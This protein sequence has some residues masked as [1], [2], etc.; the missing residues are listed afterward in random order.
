MTRR[1]STDRRLREG[2]PPG[3]LLVASL[4]LALCAALLLP[5]AAPAAVA[6]AI[7]GT[8]FSR[9]TESSAALSAAVDPGS[10]K[11]GARFQY[12]TLAAFEAHGFEG[13]QL[14]PAADISLPTKVVGSGDTVAGSN[15]IA[16]V[17]T[18]AGAFGVGQAISGAGIPAATTI[19]AVGADGEG[20]VTQL[21]LSKPLGAT[22]GGVKLEATGPQPI[23]AALGALAPAA[24]YVFRVHAKNL[25][26]EEKDGP[27]L[28]FYTLAPAPSF[29]SCPNDAFRTGGLAPAAR[30]SALLPDCRAYEQASP[31]EKDG[32]DALG[33]KV[34]SRAAATGGAVTFG[35]AFGMPD[36]EGA[37]A[38]PFF[39]ARRDPTGWSST[40]LLPPASLGE[41]GAYLRG[42]TPDFSATY[43]SATRKGAPDTTALFELHPDGTPPTRI[44]PY[45]P[46]S[47]NTDYE[48]AGAA[49]DGSTVLVGAPLALAGEEGGETIPGS[50]PGHP[51]VYAW[52]RATGGL[53]L[54]GR[55]NTLEETEE[56]L[57]KGAYAGP[58]EWAFGNAGLGLSPEVAA[59]LYYLT[60][61]HAVSADGSL[62]FTSL[63]DGR[64]YRRLHPGEPQSA[65]DSEGDCT[66]PDKACTVEISAS[67]RTV[68]DPAG[69]APAIFMA[70]SADGSRAFFASSQM[71]TDD[72]NTGPEQPE[73][74][75]GRAKPNDEAPAGEVEEDFV[76]AHAVGLAVDP[77]GEHLYWAD[78]ARGTIG[79]ARLD[80]AGEATQLEPNFLS[81]P[82]VPEGI[83]E[84]EV[85]VGK[86]LQF[87][88]V[89]VP[90]HPRYV[91]L[92]GEYIYWTNTGRSG[93][94][95][96][97]PLDGGGTIG[98]AK[99]SGEGADEI[100][101]AFICGEDKDEPGERRVSN[102]QG[103]AV[104]E[105]HVYWAN[106]AA[107]PIFNSIWRAASGGGEVEKA[108]QTKANRTPYGVALSGGRVYFT[109][110]SAGG[111]GGFVS[112]APATGGEEESNHIYEEGLR[113]LAIAGD[114][115]YWAAQKE[116]AIGRVPLAELGFC[117]ATPSCDREYLAPAGKLNGLAADPGGRLYWSANGEAPSNPGA[118]LYRYEAG[119][120]PP[121]TDLTPDAGEEDGA[122]VQGVLAASEDGSH[123]YFAANGVLADNSVDR[124]NGPE[125]AQ[126][127][128]C[129]GPQ[130]RFKETFGGECNLYLHHAG[131]VTFIARLS[132]DSKD[133]DSVDWIPTPNEVFN[134]GSYD[135]KSA[136]ASA[137]GGVLLFRSEAQLT[138]YRNEGVAELYRYEADSGALACVSCR[139]SGEAPHE[140]PGL[141]SSGFPA[142]EPSRAGAQSVSVRFL[143]AD[144][145]RAFFESGEALVGGD[146]NGQQGCPQ[147]LLGAPVCVDVY[148]WEAPGAGSCTVGGP[149][150]SPLNEGCLYLLSPGQSP[151]PSLFLD[152]SAGG[153][154]VYFLSRRRLVG[155]DGDELLDAYDA[156]AGGGLAAQNPLER[157]PCEAEGCKPAASAPPPFAAPPRFS[158]P[159]DAKPKPRRCRRGRVRRHGRCVSS[160]RHHAKRH[161]RRRGGNR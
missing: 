118:D 114:H 87:V 139:P 64:L 39:L 142:A 156:R 115:I 63:A 53:T 67:R 108:L 18:T 40:G 117:E 85:E 84:E 129:K 160:R 75:I 91:T 23:A 127:G 137:D 74:Q 157:P 109:T 82:E 51:N 46:I 103:I 9:V 159:P 1:A 100:E 36:G 141:G 72:A 144:G 102:P 47:S 152:A 15:A 122:G 43:A 17:T 151:G 52:D 106:A 34:Y 130:V 133:P 107:D 19:V 49:A 69:Q 5:A 92:D 155:Q 62:F 76:S 24:G 121:L 140:P 28:T 65:L 150:Y 30:P 7:S 38:F 131:Q 3:A 54:A 90:A 104:G 86:V 35:S 95:P 98:R 143:S 79:R 60:D 57:T 83:C 48:Y 21:T 146:T 123:V 73:A 10:S 138:G 148:E 14:A 56:G 154:D 2:P 112:S 6:P 45:S 61:T 22:A 33:T 145:D 27:A 42:F 50:A 88:P 66:E 71:L 99:L 11:S 94:I 147:T 149:G 124:G 135:A 111:N 25:L 128:D 125:V 4:A 59:R 153:E 120:S 70:A 68:P 81:V 55:L 29:G 113:G 31:T 126:P 80:G 32:S 136:R 13:A 8:A 41:E 96:E 89:A 105:G 16:N 93:G 26:G 161:D 12:T 101:P 132:L 110:N 58:Y 97:G 119:A 116:G 78:P 44:T 37:Q 77:A 158:G 134:T 20:V